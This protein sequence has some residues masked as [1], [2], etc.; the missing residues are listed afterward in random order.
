MQ[1]TALETQITVALDVKDSE[2]SGVNV[3]TFTVYTEL[4][5]TSLC[6]RLFR[7]VRCKHL[8][9]N[10]VWV[11]LWCVAKLNSILAVQHRLIAV[12][13]VWYLGY[14]KDVSLSLSLEVNRVRLQPH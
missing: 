8:K 14:T 10:H 12:I 1:K 13:A 6:K 7:V 11:V 5:T 4:Q 3:D 9:M 2:K